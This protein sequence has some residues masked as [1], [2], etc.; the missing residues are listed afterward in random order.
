MKNNQITHSLPHTFEVHHKKVRRLL[1]NRKTSISLP[2]ATHVEFSS[3][4][5]PSLQ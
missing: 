3:S 2:V 4:L 5:N 1:A